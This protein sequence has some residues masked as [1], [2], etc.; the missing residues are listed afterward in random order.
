MPFTRGRRPS[1]RATSALRGLVVGFRIWCRASSRIV[2]ARAKKVGD[3]TDGSGS[4]ARTGKP[5]SVRVCGNCLI[6]QLRQRQQA[7]LA[8]I[9][10]TSAFRNCAAYFLEAVTCP[11]RTTVAASDITEPP[12]EDETSGKCDYDYY[13]RDSV[14]VWE[15]SRAWIEL[16][17]ASGRRIS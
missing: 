5:R 7:G 16:V 17:N 15:V 12:G 11:Q 10:R 1:I 2:R 6:R 4:N 9:P 13:S 3:V 8:T 14:I